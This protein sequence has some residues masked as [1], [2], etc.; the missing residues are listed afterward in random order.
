[1]PQAWRW[2]EGLRKPR[3]GTNVFTPR[4]PDA[5]CGGPREAEK[6]ARTTQSRDEHLEVE[7]VLRHGGLEQVD[8]D[9]DPQRGD[10]DG[11]HR[12]AERI[13]GRHE[14]RERQRDFR[15][16]QALRLAAARSKPPDDPS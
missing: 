13:R 7:L 10:R 6:P 12:R 16:D 8:E 11:E 4:G 15:R 2:G 1:M 3:L 14:A 5:R 9:E